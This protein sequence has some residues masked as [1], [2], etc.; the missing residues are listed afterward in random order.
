MAATI[1]AG[2]CALKRVAGRAG[3]ER[4]VDNRLRARGGPAAA[5][6]ARARPRQLARQR[7][8]VPIDQVQ[9][10]DDRIG[11]Q[12]RRQ[13]Q[14]AR[15]SALAALTHD[16]EVA[17]SGASAKRGAQAH[18]ENRRRV[19]QKQLHVCAPFSSL[20]DERPPV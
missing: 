11:R 10:S 4:L 6:V 20:E 13:G 1:S 15:P 14:L 12:R 5:P 3:A 8:A 9:V 17:S 7:D 2:G 16:V 18:P 19:H